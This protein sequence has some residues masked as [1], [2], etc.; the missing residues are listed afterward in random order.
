MQCKTILAV[1]ALLLSTFLAPLQ[2]GACTAITL[3]AKDGSVI[4]ARTEE[5][6]HLI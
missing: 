5:W 2:V 6:A 1:V 3:K 4:Q